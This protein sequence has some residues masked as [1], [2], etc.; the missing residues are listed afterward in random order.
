MKSVYLTFL[1]VLIFAVEGEYEDSLNSNSHENLNLFKKKSCK[2][3][4][5]GSSSIFHFVLRIL[6]LKAL[7]PESMSMSTHPKLLQTS[8][9]TVETFLSDLSLQHPNIRINGPCDLTLRHPN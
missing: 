9:Y 3:F 1:Q 8:R 2:T 5:K 6:L 7:R 4:T